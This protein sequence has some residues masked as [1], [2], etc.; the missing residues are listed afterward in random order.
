M[1]SDTGSSAATAE[2]V[3]GSGGARERVADLWDD[4]VA[5]WL[6]GDRTLPPDLARWKA[7]YAGQTDEDCYPDPFVGDLRGETGDPALVVLG[8]NP[9]VGYPQLQAPDGIW[10]QRIAKT[11]YSRCLDRVPFGDDAWT[12]LHGRDST[13]WNRLMK[14]A[15]RY[16]GQPSLGVPQVLNLELYPWHSPS[17]DGLMQP[18]AELLDT[19]VWQPVAELPRIRHVFAFAKGWFGICAELGWPLLHQYG[20]PGQPPV[21]GWTGKGWNLAVFA[22]PSGQRAVV[23]WQSGYAGPPGA[24]RTEALRALL[25]HLD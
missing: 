21:P 25:E 23:S 2:A 3:G 22:M 18:P 24:E 14:F 6:D 9:G 11:G 7:S 15:R 5:R 10:A 8:I 13:Y 12:E 4:V 20:G 1:R 16:T 17:V 19:Y